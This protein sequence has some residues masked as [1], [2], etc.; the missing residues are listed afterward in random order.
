MD[1]RTCLSTS[2]PIAPF[3]LPRLGNE[4]SRILKMELSTLV[5]LVMACGLRV[6]ADGTN[7]RYKEGDHVPLYANKVGPF[8]N[9]SETY[10]YYDLPF[11]SPGYSF[12][13]TVPSTSELHESVSN[14]VYRFVS[15]YNSLQ[16][17]VDLE[18]VTEKTDAL[19]EALNGDRL[20]DAPYELIFLEEQRSKS[21][22]KKNLSKEDVAKFRH[23]VSKDYYFEMYYDDLPFWGFLGKIEGVKTDSG[24]DK[25]FLFK[26]IHFNIL[27][28]DDRVIEINV[29]TDPNINVDISED[30]KL[31]VEFLYSVTW[32]NTDISFEERMTKY[33]RTSSM[34]QYLEIHWFSIVNSCVTVLL[35]TGFLATILM[36]VLKNDFVKYS[37]IEESLEDQEDSGWKYIHGDVFRF[38]NNKSLFSV[39]IGSGTQL[40][41]LVPKMM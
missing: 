2:E 10:R 26:H 3:G 23:A 25:Y 39:I 9:P 28:N 7:H 16:N 6:G 20:V 31:D 21:L 33:S 34:P 14:T 18:H 22:C 30:R 19:G 4:G 29:Q 41:V 8:H 12:I 35:L 5:L 24:K 11:C 38:P 13:L 15:V 1:S 17:F 32:K 40:L 36:R 27:Y 37:L